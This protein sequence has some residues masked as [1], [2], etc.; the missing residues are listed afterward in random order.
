MGDA[1]AVVLLA[2]KGFQ[3]VDFAVRHPGGILG[4]RLLLRVEDLMHRGKELPLVEQETAIK[5]ALFE[6]SEKRLGLTGIIDDQGNL[7]GMITDGDLRRGLQT[8]GNGIF[9]KKAME[10]MTLKPHTIAVKQALASEALTRTEAN[11][12]RLHHLSVC[13]RTRKQQ[14]DRCH[15]SARYPKS[16]DL[17]SCETVSRRSSQESGKD[18]VAAPRCRRRIDRRPDRSSTTAASRPNIFTSATVRESLC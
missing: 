9:S 14:T 11:M 5:D 13:T 12:P 2:E 17:I 18:Q 10:V 16:G 4:R 3:E 6:I 1:L 7:V 15:P 8:H